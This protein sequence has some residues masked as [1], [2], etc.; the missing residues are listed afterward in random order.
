MTINVYFQSSSAFKLEWYLNKQKINIQNS[1]LNAPSAQHHNK[2]SSHC[3]HSNIFDHEC[4]L[5]IDYYDTKDTGNYEAVVT[6]K[7]YPNI[8]I[9]I[10]T[11]VIMP[12]IFNFK[13]I[14]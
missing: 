10:S 13:N 9:N 5:Y 12:S 6:L 1:T 3:I 14:N 4:F 2:Y 7:D 11:V 8:S